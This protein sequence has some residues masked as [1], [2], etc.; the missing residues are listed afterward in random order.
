M[1]LAINVNNTQIK[2]ALYPKP[3]EDGG[4]RV[5][6]RVSTDWEKTEDEYGILFAEL[7]AHA[8]LSLGDVR[9]VAISC[10]V[11]PLVDTMERLCERYFRTR[12]LVVGPGVRTGMRI[13]YENPREVG[14]DRICNAVA[15]YAK[16]GGPSLV[17]DFGTATTLALAQARG[18]PPKV[19]P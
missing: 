12:P 19:E 11:P 6:W 14:A 13:L 5:H 2:L 17:C 3:E 15:A 18:F 9:D 16:Y 8:G 1:L 7:F 4:P 10:V